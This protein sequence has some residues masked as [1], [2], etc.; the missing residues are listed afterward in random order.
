MKSILTYRGFMYSKKKLPLNI[1][2]KSHAGFGTHC[3]AGVL[4]V[5]GSVLHQNLY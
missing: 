1:L 2:M 4:P 3:L 5:T